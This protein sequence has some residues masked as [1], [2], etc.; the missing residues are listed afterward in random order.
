MLLKYQLITHNNTLESLCQSL[1]NKRVI[2][3]DTEFIRVRTYY[4][5]IGLI[6]LFDGDNLALIDPLAIDNWQCFV[7]MLQNKSQIKYFHACGEDIDVFMH[8]FNLLPSP[9]LDSQILAAFLDNDL[10]TSYATLVNK[11]LNV[12]LNKTET[13]TN[14]LSRPLSNKQCCYAAEDVYYL[15]QLTDKLI[16]IVEKKGWLKAAKEECQTFSAKKSALVSPSHAYL[17]IKKA[18]QLKGIELSYLQLLAAWRLQYAIEHNIAVNL[19]LP[20]TLI[21]KIAYYKPSSLTEL[22]KLGAHERE[23]R[24]YGNVIME[25]LCQPVNT[26]L[27]PIKPIT[28]YTNYITVTEHLRQA[29]AKIAKE[30]GLNKSI[31]LSRRHINHYVKWLDNKNES[32]PEIISGWRAPLFEPYLATV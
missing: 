20:E 1:I 18:S 3:L 30:T 27:T 28:N 26:H 4:P 32:K 2:A 22:K 17:N 9:I 15:L 23:I 8:E 25:L 12:T 29:A 31:L 5:E 11:Y 21:W 14:W 7:A 16:E 19:V 6:Q 24:L 13:R 10:C